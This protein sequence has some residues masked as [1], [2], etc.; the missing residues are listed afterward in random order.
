MD[1][2]IKLSPMVGAYAAVVEG[3]SGWD[4]GDNNYG[5]I[6]FYDAKLRVP[7]G[8]IPA[9]TIVN[10]ICFCPQAASVLVT[11]EKGETIARATF[12]CVIN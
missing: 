8:G 7:I 11:D 5:D 10:A 4:Q 3:F 6:R 2:A 12:K 1:N 9:G